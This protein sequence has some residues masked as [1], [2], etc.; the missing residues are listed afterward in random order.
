M[1]SFA[2]LWAG[3]RGSYGMNKGK[4][5]FEMKVR[6]TFCVLLLAFCLCGVKGSLTDLWLWNLQVIEKIPV[7]HVKS[8]NMDVHDVQIGWSLANGSLLLGKAHSP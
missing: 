2:Y 7:K 1:E 4:A 6:R 8:K 5:C 3:G